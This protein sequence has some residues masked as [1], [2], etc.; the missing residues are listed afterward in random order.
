MKTPFEMMHEAKSASSDDQE[1][2]EDSLSPRSLL[3]HFS[4]QT[5]TPTPSLV[6][7]SPTESSLIDHSSQSSS[8]SDVEPNNESPDFPKFRLGLLSQ[9]GSHVDQSITSSPDFPKFK[10][11]LLSPKN[12]DEQHSSPDFPKFRP[13]LLTDDYNSTLTSPDFPKIHDS[14]LSQQNEHNHPT[15]C[16]MSTFKPSHLY[17]HNSANTNISPDF[18]KFRP[19]L[20]NG[21]RPSSPPFKLASPPYNH[22]CLRSSNFS[23]RSD[24]YS[25]PTSPSNSSGYITPHLK[26]PVSPLARTSAQSRFPHIR[27]ILKPPTGGPLVVANQAQGRTPVSPLRKKVLQHNADLLLLRK[28]EQDSNDL[29][30][31]ASSDHSLPTLPTSPTPLPAQVPASS[32]VNRGRLSRGS[33]NSEFCH[34]NPLIEYAEPDNAEDSGVCHAFVSTLDNFILLD[35]L[36]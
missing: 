29:S 15:G 26:C 25:S 16:H 34:L 4:I 20:L 18:P 21:H 17:Q 3:Q 22:S 12:P 11:G 6:R 23:P 30:E 24:F 31:K 35:C 8:E 14:L 5:A 19:G 9:E 7:D 1:T 32:S 2:D 33:P 28:G 13:G 27:S 36:G 10:P